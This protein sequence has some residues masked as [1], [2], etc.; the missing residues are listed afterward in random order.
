MP[1]AAQKS[2]CKYSR[3][4]I[5]K[6]TKV[7]ILVTKL[8]RITKFFDAAAFVYGVAEG[9]KK[10]LGVQIVTKKYLASRPSQADLDEAVIVP[11]GSK[12]IILFED[13]STFQLVTDTAYNGS[14]IFDSPR[15]GGNSNNAYEV[16]TT[17]SIQYPVNENSIKTLTSKAAKSIR[18]AIG[19][20]N[21]DYNFGKKET[22]AVQEILTCIE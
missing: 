19:N 16:I 5:D 2:E 8:Q 12:I 11:K 13:E 1:A 17:T 14:S 3:N 4:E 18:V 7:K 10:S 20:S 15:S 6:F 9:E 21:Y 22:G